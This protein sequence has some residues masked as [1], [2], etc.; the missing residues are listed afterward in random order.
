MHDLDQAFANLG[1]PPTEPPATSAFSRPWMVAGLAIIIGVTIDTAALHQPPGVGLMVGLWIALLVAAS[2]STL[3]GEP[4]SSGLI[5]VLA[6]GLVLAGFVGVRTSPVMLSLNIAATVVVISVLAQLHKA[7]GVSGWTITRYG[8]H[9]LTTA[10]DMTSGAGR[11]VTTDLRDGFGEEHSTRIRSVALGLALGTPLLIVFGSLFASADSVFGDYLDQLV[12]GVIFGNV[13]WRAMFS[14]SLGLAI[15]GLWRTLR[16]PRAPIIAPLHR[17]RIDTTTGIT[18]LALL[19]ALFMFFVMTQVVGQR[20]DLVRNADF[21]ENAREGF[22]QL[23]TVAFLVLNVL[24]LFD[25]LTRADDERRSPAFD[26]LAIVLIGLTGIV[27]V[28]ALSRMRLYV[29]TFGLTELRFY[30][31][32]FM[33]W[34]AF[35]L[36]WF[37]RTVLR[38]RRASF[39]VGLLASGVVFIVGLNLV[40][41]D[42]LIVDLNWDRYLDG[43]VFSDRYN[44]ELS[45]DSLLTLIAVRES[46]PADRWCF[47]EERLL[48]SR[49][50]LAES[51]GEHGVLA[52]SWASWRARNALNALQLAERDGIECAVPALPAS[53]R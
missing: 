38:N 31:S 1:P 19:V 13:F 37:I 32:V 17:R 34:L 27:M 14:L 47:I 26:R 39:A 22:F 7:G 20:T 44:S 6:T 5:P 40:N 46:E 48:R 33:F 3:L 12:N 50:A 25:W 53:S 35:V 8:R 28:S 4:R 11:F 51:W 29:D 2:I 45:A 41:P 43:E 18:V 30:T 49:A 10:A 36:I 9:P 21:S 42:S 23:V 24:L 52:E 15:A 16:A